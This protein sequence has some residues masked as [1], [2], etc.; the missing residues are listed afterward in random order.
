M[1]PATTPPAS[2]LGSILQGVAAILAAVAWPVAISILLVTN[3]RMVYDIL[4]LLLQKLSRANKIRIGNAL[5]INEEVERKLDTEEENAAKAAEETG[6]TRDVPQSEREVAKRVGSIS[7]ASPDYTSALISAR[8]RMVAFAK[9]YE[10]VRANM[11]PGTDRTLHMNAVVSKMRAFSLAVK[12]LLVRFSHSDSPGQR[13]A[14]ITILQIS[15]NAKYADW[16]ADRMKAEDPFIFFHAALAL[17]ETVRSKG[18]RFPI[19]LRKALERAKSTVES[20]TGGPP[21]KNTIEIL[22]QALQELYEM[23]GKRE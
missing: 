21:D 10:A 16:L 12:P 20:Y 5:E 11:P 7:G 8:S 9:E 15:P 4:R 3:R 17:L 13:L 22:S 14:G 19:R 23:T 18:E 2:N 1:I 6:L